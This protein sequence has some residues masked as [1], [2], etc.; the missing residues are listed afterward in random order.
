MDNYEKMN[1]SDNSICI[2]KLHQDGMFEEGFYIGVN[3][4][5]LIK[6]MADNLQIEVSDLRAMI[7]SSGNAFFAQGYDGFYFQ[8]IEDAKKFVNNYIIPTLTM[9]RLRGCK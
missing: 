4:W 9:K 7:Q 2:F 1:I 3:N 5:S 8:N 6:G